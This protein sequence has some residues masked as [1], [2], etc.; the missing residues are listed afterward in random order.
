MRRLFHRGVNSYI[1]FLDYA[2]E[3]N[4]FQ[5]VS[6]AGHH[7]AKEHIEEW[8]NVKIKLAVVGDSGVG[9]SSF[10]NTIRG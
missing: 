10:I 6:E 7:D 3:R 4:V 8:Q 2:E 9:K 1:S 5:K